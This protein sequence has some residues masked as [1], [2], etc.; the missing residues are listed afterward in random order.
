MVPILANVVTSAAQ[1]WWPLTA[2]LGAFSMIFWPLIRSTIGVRER[3]TA[4][5]I[6]GKTDQK[7]IERLDDS[8]K[9]VLKSLGEIKLQLARIEPRH[10]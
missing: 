2:I 10:T 6:Q 5:E 3:L 8:M 7:A 4:L 9:E 1:E